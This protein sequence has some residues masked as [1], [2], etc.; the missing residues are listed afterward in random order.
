[1]CL[2]KITRFSIGSLL[3]QMIIFVFLRQNIN[4]ISRSSNAGAHTCG[5]PRLQKN[6]SILK[7]FIGAAVTGVKNY[8][9]SRI[10]TAK[11]VRVARQL[12]NAASSG[13]HTCSLGPR[14]ITGHENPSSSGYLAVYSFKNVIYY[15]VRNLILATLLHCVCCASWPASAKATWIT[16]RRTDRHLGITLFK[17][18]L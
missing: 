4:S 9:G 15:S 13:I 14:E 1:M 12:F 2:V 18:Q 17:K 16:D 11:A 6:N 7:R 10:C 3:T 8:S 5:Q